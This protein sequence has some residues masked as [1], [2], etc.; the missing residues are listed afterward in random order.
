V[1]KVNENKGFFRIRK[2]QFFPI[3]ATVFKT[4]NDLF[5][6]PKQTLTLK[7]DVYTLNLQLDVTGNGHIKSG[8][9]WWN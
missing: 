8:A 4:R 3:S 7:L 1:G 5:M 2:G 9:S 6:T